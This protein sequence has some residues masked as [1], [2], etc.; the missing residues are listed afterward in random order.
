MLENDLLEDFVLFCFLFSSLSLR[1]GVSFGFFDFP[2]LPPFLP[3]PSPRQ[4][5]RMQNPPTSFHS[6]L[7]RLVLAEKLTPVGIKSELSKCGSLFAVLPRTRLQYD[8]PAPNGV[9]SRTNALRRTRH[10]VPS[11]ATKS[12][13]ARSIN[14]AIAKAGR[15]TGRQARR[16]VQ[17]QDETSP[18]YSHNKALHRSDLFVTTRKVTAEASVEKSKCSCALH[19][20]SERTRLYSQRAVHNFSDERGGE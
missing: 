3:S 15:Q 11:V 13:S 10:R 6:P 8:G 19:L 14:E 2:S 17:S 1:K 16:Q 7:G 12:E 4:P 5:A 20:G 18:M 9:S